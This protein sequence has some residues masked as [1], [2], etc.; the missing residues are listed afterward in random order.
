M[1]KYSKYDGGKNSKSKKKTKDNPEKAAGQKLQNVPISVPVHELPPTTH[2]VICGGVEDED[3][4]M[5]CDGPNCQRETHMY[6]MRPAL[7]SIPEGQWFCDICDPL[8]TTKN[9]QQYF[10]EHNK[11]RDSLRLNDEMEDYSIFLRALQSN[12]VNFE[13]WTLQSFIDDESEMVTSEFDESA[14]DL[15]GCK[16]QVY[17]YIDERTHTGRIINRRRNDRFHYYEHLIQFKR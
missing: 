14:I 7:C 6:C 9:L 15:V 10:E 17:C 1:K 8:G 2:C 13:E 4:I 11:L 12:C 3:L 16:V 5:L